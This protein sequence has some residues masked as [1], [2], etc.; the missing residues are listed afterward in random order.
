ML[1]LCNKS[2]SSINIVK[3]CILLI[4]EI[5]NIGYVNVC[6]ESM[7]CLEC[8]WEVILIKDYFC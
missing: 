4:Y 6:E 1:V 2:Y 7:F 8:L 5:V 3:L